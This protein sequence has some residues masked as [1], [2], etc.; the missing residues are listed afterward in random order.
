M[1]LSDDGIG[2]RVSAE[3]RKRK[4]LAGAQIVDAGCALASVLLSHEE[5]DVIV[6][7]DAVKGGG[8]P[9]DVYRF[10]I[11]E[12][13]GV[14]R[15]RS[16]YKSVHEIGLEDSVALARLAWRRTPDIIAIGIEPASLETG[17]ELSPALSLRFGSI[18]DYVEKEIK[19]MAEGGE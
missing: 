11:D 19:R 7:L 1:L 18:V 5:A 6:I 8:A 15:A 4:W 14:R 10:R 3:L 9:G 13:P 12:L 17:L 16:P 2:S